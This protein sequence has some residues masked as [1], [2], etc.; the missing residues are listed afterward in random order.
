MKKPIT[1]VSLF[2]LGL[3]STIGR[4]YSNLRIYLEDAKNKIYL[5]SNQYPKKVNS[6]IDSKKFKIDRL[7]FEVSN[8]CN[9]KCIFCAYDDISKNPQHKKGIMDFKI[10]KKAVD[11]AIRMGVENI[12]LTPT[13]G[14]PLVDKGI[15]EKIRYVK[16]KKE[17]KYLYF[18]TNGILLNKNEN[19]KKIVDSG[20][21]EIDV[22][23]AGFNEENWIKIF[24]V[25]SYKSHLYGLSNLLKYA[26]G[27]KSTIKININLRTNLNPINIYFQNDFKKYILPYITNKVNIT[28]MYSYDNWGGKIQKHDLLPNMVLRREY[29]FKK[30]PCKRLFDAAILFD[31]SVRLCACRA[32]DTEFDDLVIGNIKNDSLDDIFYG[33]TAQ[34][35]RK[36]FLNGNYPDTC[37]KCSAYSP[38]KIL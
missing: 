2:K 31:G 11:D 23:T 33:E 10:F 32:I 3:L 34:S 25:T 38:L 16:N 8:I 9:G 36:N 27:E 1:F 13:I 12:S 29:T 24:G 18:Y 35:I 14:D 30:I 20:I 26:K 28:Y 21:N 7:Y 5:D 4:K 22:S 17:I 6:Y 19:Y 15:F 37:E